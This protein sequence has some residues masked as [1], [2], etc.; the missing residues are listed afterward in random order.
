MYQLLKNIRKSLLNFKKI[1][2]NIILSKIYN[3]IQKTP[4]PANQIVQKAREVQ[5]A[6]GS[7]R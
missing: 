4:G 1:I 2:K 6:G 3:S 7:R 5:I